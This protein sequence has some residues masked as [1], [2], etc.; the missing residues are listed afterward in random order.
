MAISNSDKLVRIRDISTGKCISKINTGEF[1][2]GMA[3]SA[4]NKHFI[5]TTIDGSI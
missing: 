5:T 1:C 3:F 4:N 2:T